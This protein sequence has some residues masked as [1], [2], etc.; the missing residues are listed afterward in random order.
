[1]NYDGF[2]NGKLIKFS[3]GRLYWYDLGIATDCNEK[4]Y[5]VIH[6]ENIYDKKYR[7]D[8]PDAVLW[9]A[10]RKSVSPNRFFL[11]D[12]EKCFLVAFKDIDDFE[13]VE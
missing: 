8:I 6:Y 4:N 9:K 7:N 13:V 11:F 5:L 10:G 1:M 3:L 12:G 2:Y